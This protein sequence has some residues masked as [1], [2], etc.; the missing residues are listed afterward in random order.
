[1]FV[2]RV[3]EFSTWAEKNSQLLI[4]AAV[5]VVLLAGAGLYYVSYRN[6]VDREA[7]AEIERVQQ[8]AMFLPDQA[9]ADVRRYLE[10]FGGTRHAAEARLLLGQILLVQDR[11]QEAAVALEDGVGS[12]RSPMVIATRVLLGR[13]YESLG[14]TRDAEQQYMTVAEQADLPFQRRDALAD[15]AR[16]RAVSGDHAGAAE[17][18]RR[19]L[20]DLDAAHADRGLYEMRLAEEEHAARG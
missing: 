7:V 13:A 19:I 9:E 12:G 6:N 16:V 18:Y 11:A 14:R 10:R 2:A 4:L 17:L 20:S 1:V 5:A 15:A 3:F 8:I